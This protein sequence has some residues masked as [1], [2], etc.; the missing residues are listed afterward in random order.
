MLPFFWVKKENWKTKETSE[1]KKL[2]LL[3]CILMFDIIDCAL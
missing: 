1:I 3:N 2:L